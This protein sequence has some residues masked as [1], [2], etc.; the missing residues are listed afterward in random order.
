[1][2][3]EREV[4]GLDSGT[5]PRMTWMIGMTGEGEGEGKVKVK[6]LDSGTS[7]RMTWTTWMTWTTGAMAVDFAS[8]T[9]G[10]LIFLLMIVLVCDIINLIYFL[11]FSLKF[12][13]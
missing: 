9:F 10:C 2:T 12:Q 11:M 13:N 5:S 1:M 8:I 6:G 7:P 3:G 4:K